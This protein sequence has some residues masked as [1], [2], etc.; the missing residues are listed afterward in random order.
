[1]HPPQSVHAY[2]FED[3]TRATEVRVANVLALPVVIDRVRVNGRMLA[4]QADWISED[5]RALLHVEAVPAVVLRGG[6]E[7]AARYVSLR[8][9]AMD[10]LTGSCSAGALQLVTHLIGLDEEVIVD[11]MCDR[12]AD[13]SLADLPP[14]PTLQDALARHPFLGETEWADL[15][16]LHPGTWHVEGDLIL[17]EN[18]SLWTTGP[19][20]LTFDTGAVLLATAPLLLVGSNDQRIRLLPHDEDWGGVVVFGAGDESPSRLEN[21][22]IG[23][24]TGVQRPGWQSKGGI[25]FYASSV[26]MD[27]CRLLGSTA[28]QALYVTDADFAVLSTELALAAFDGFGGERV[29]GRIEQSAFHDIVGNA[30]SLDESRVIIEDTN[31]LRIYGTAIWGDDGSVVRV[32][33][34]AIEDVGFGVVSADMS[35]VQAQDLR[36]AQAWLG[37]FA[38]YDEDI[39]H[40]AATIAVTR[41]TLADGSTPA[42]IGGGGTVQFDRSIGPVDA[43][44]MDPDA[45]RDRSQMARAMH[46]VDYALGRGIRLAGY[47]LSTAELAP[48]D[49]L[50]LV[51]YW[52]AL[53]K[54]S[55]DYTVFVHVLDATGQIAAQWDA[56]PRENTF[57]TT[58]WP[59]GVIVDDPRQVPLPLDV[60]PGEYSIAL[61]MYDRQTRDRLPVH[62][63]DGEPIVDGAI[64]IERHVRVN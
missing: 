50:Q 13:L 26:S 33:E 1:M 32:R 27:R 19:V 25:A 7:P 34:V 8:I 3:T 36:V 12:V 10:G 20:T 49:T 2:W 53:T 9:P 47:E 52:Q 23:A 55:R 18:V 54:L 40:S 29:Q 28:P 21:V 63:P 37:A 57:L 22:E 39:G 5:D 48:G 64:L 59:V 61:G 44:E 45:P 6:H 43:V 4:V 41:L 24:T 46:V 11:V 30:I 17:P 14:Q 38:S 51:L 31:L 60:P 42:L 58:A 56:M 15:L 16:T 35:V 62:G